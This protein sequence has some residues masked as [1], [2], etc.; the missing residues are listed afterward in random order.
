M[1]S[2]RWKV[3]ELRE[4]LRTGQLLPT[5]PLLDRGHPVMHDCFVCSLKEQVVVQQTSLYEGDVLTAPC[6]FRE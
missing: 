3:T 6:I 1:L 2:H 4:R 5:E